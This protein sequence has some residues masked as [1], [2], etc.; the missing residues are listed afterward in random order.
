MKNIL[1]ASMLSLSLAAPVF[2]EVVVIVNPANTANISDD[3]IGRLFLG[4]KS[5]FSDGSKAIPI[6]LAQGHAARDEFNKK[7]LGKSSSQLKAYWSKL[8]FTGKGTPPN[9]LGSVNDVIEKI[10]TD[11]SAIAYID[12][13]SVNDSV[14]V[15]ATY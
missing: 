6:Y 12:A 10:S 7:A 15:V 11:P 9:A 4:K 3:D 1:M 14:K 8:I 2:A 13:A 5:K